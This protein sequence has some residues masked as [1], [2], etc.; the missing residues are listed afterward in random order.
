MLGTLLA[1]Q[2]VAAGLVGEQHLPGAER[3]D[4]VE[5]GDEVLGARELVPGERLRLAHVRRH[6]QRLGLDSA[7]ERLPSASSTVGTPL[8]FASRIASR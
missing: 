2:R 4:L 1:K 5:G 3:G 7:G 8:R 6:D